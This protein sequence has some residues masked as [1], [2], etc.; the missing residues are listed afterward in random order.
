MNDVG[1]M[2]IR[3]NSKIKREFRKLPA[4]KKLDNISSTNSFII[5]YIYEHDGAVYQK[6]IEER[7]GITRST[8]SK[9]ISL[10]EQKDL[11]KRED[12]LNDSRKKKVIL[13]DKAIELSKE[14]IKE[15][16]EFEKR[17]NEVLGDNLEDFN[18]SLLILDSF[19]SGG[20]K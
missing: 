10:M 6:D 12:D 1:R 11:I 9:V 7:F 16:N 18:K 20:E 14:F 2:I 4:I 13:T 19:F 3:L 17:I 5:I 8:V 15:K